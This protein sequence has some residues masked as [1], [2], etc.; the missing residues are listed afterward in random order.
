M[1]RKKPTR[2][3]RL[4][5]WSI[6]LALPLAGW[7]C[8]L[9]LNLDWTRS[10]GDVVDNYGVAIH[11]NGAIVHEDGRNLSPGG[12]N[13]GLRWQCVEFVKR[14]YFEHYGHRMP[15]A[16]GNAREF[17]DEGVPNGTVNPARGLLQFRNDGSALPN[18]D[19]IVVFGGWLANPYGHVAIVSRVD[20]DGIETVQQNPGPFRASQERISIDMA[21]GHPS[22]TGHRLLGW[23]R[24]P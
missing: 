14:S 3:T 12:Y 24:R 18:V 6:V 19:D 22:L 23:L 1:D 7:W 9:H 4:R 21:G 16:R 15:E 11:Y 20:S 10:P 13:L 17:F 8:A 5:A 2:K